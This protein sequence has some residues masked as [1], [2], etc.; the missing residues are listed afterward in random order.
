MGAENN[1]IQGT[2]TPSKPKRTRMWWIARILG[3]LLILLFIGLAFPGHG[4]LNAGRK[5]IALTMTNQFDVACQMYKTE[6]GCYPSTSENYRLYIIL[7][8]GKLEKDNSRGIQFMSFNKREISP[9]GEI[10]D[11]WQTP[12]RIVFDDKGVLVTSAGKDKLFGTK[13][14]I[15]NRDHH[16]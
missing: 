4:P 15:T 8:G 9:N 1:P 2:G 5:A 7:N 3:A 6:Y 11:P 10:L 12:Y 14:D 13:D 16:D